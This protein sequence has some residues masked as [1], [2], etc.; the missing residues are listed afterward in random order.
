MTEIGKMN[1]LRVI[2]TDE[3]GVWLDGGELGNI[4]MP[5]SLADKDYRID[6]QPEVFLYHDSERQLMATTKVPFAMVNEFALLKVVSVSPAGAFLDWGLKKDLLVPFGEQKQKMQEGKSYIVFVLFDDK[7][8]RIIASS[9]LAKFLGRESMDLHEGQE[10]SLLISNQ[11]E[12]GFEAIINNSLSGLLYKNE[13]FQP[14]RKGQKITGYI[15]KIREDGKIDLCLQKPGHEKIAGI[16]ENIINALKKQGG[17]I[18]VTDKSPAEVIYSL[19]GISKK[20]YKKAI[21]SLYKERMIAI[22]ETGIR[23]IDND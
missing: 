13:V 7:S 9:K 4:L 3:A 2:S 6:D 8:A 5:R 17:F 23:L 14:L 22:E 11:T 15:K 16:S 21:G 20:T 19:F 1:R 12:I 18:A 10:V